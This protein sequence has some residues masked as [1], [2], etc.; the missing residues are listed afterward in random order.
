MANAVGGLGNRFGAGAG[1]GGGMQVGYGGGVAWVA[2]VPA[3]SAA[4]PWPRRHRGAA[5]PH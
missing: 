3:A 4:F 5:H 2:S 1:A